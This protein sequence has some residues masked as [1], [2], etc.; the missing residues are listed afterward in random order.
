M[1][2]VKDKLVT[3]ESIGALHDYNMQRVID[4]AHGGTGATNA[5]EARANLGLS[6][7]NQIIREA[8]GQQAYVDAT[9]SKVLV[10][11]V[12]QVSIVAK[13]TSSD[14]AGALITV[15]DHTN[16]GTM[17]GLI[18]MKAPD[19][20]IEAD[21]IAVND[22]NHKVCNTNINGN[23]NLNVVTDGTTNQNVVGGGNLKV[24]GN[25]V[26]DGTAEFNDILHIDHAIYV[27]GAHT[28]NSHAFGLVEESLSDGSISKRLEIGKD[29]K[30]NK[31]FSTYLRGNEVGIYSNGNIYANGDLYIT[32]SK[33]GGKTKAYGEN[34]LLW[35]GET[36][37]EKAKARWM[38]VDTTNNN[39]AVVI[40]LSENVQNQPNG[41]VLVFSAYKYLDTEAHAYPKEDNV[42]N[43]NWHSFFIPKG[44]ING[45]NGH[46]RCF[47][48]FRG[49]D[50]GTKL[51]T[52]LLYI[53][54][55]QIVGHANN[56]ATDATMCG[57]TINNRMF[58]L[59]E[60]W[61]V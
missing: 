50:T 48:M 42:L 26:V 49:T 25:I 3:V 28:G 6:D 59:R 34:K 37:G 51:Y 36:K 7:A 33:I 2:E 46:G 47:T 18:Q 20:E 13:D 58:V 54:N 11:L 38:G 1:A 39:E 9:V 35:G 29:G 17:A 4:V 56:M 31:S 12:P 19:I 23:M 40:N 55:S 16:D 10:D 22:D 14:S 52:K 43:E 15:G 41:I 45:Y 5:K 44:H 24:G 30:A 53:Y 32:S 57:E 8:G 60:V 21:T 61:G 27:C